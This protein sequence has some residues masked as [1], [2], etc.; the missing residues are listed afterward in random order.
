MALTKATYSM[1]D[2]APV[3]VL[4]YGA[5][6]DGVAD[7]TAAFEA[8]RDAAGV[9]QSVYVSP[10]VYIVDTCTLSVE[11]QNWILAKGAE[12]RSINGATADAFVITADGVKISGSGVFYNGG[13]AS[14]VTYHCIKVDGADN[15]IIEGVTVGG[16]KGP[17][18]GVYDANNTII[19]G[20]NFYDTWYAGVFAQPRT[21]N[22]SGIKISDCTI[23]NT[24]SVGTDYRY[25]FNVHDDA[26]S[27]Y[28]Y[29]DVVISDNLAQFPASSTQFPLLIEVFGGAG[30]LYRLQNVS[31]TGNTLAGG[32]MGCS[33][34][35]VKTATVTGNAVKNPYLY[36]IEA[37]NTKNGS[38]T[39]NTIEGGQRGIALNDTD[40]INCSVAGNS[41]TATTQACVY[42]SQITGLLAIG[43]NSYEPATGT[44]ITLQEC[45]NWSINGG[46][47]DGTV[48][49]TKVVLL[50]KSDEG[51]ISGISA[52]D[53]SENAVLFFADNAAAYNR[54][55]VSNCVW[56][57]VTNSLN[58]TTQLSGGASIGNQF[59]YIGNRSSTDTTYRRD[60]L[61]VLANVIDFI[62]PGTPE[63]TFT[64][65]VGSIF[66][67]TD[68]GAGTTLY[69][70]QTGTG[71]TGWVGK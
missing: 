11:D 2:G 26:G 32:G 21:K 57:N 14:G 38:I 61:D 59:S 17:C 28:T 39:G 33:L 25:G 66:R 22:V 45:K 30:A 46:V 29:S 58:I 1:I 20:V 49:G 6:G 5:I 10:G 7:D 43:A 65:A 16:A 19:R 27:V 15:V 60:Y 36:G 12:I 4:D 62:G 64:G 70:K 53:F 54:V 13:L 63:G 34:S 55:I 40:T 37:A 50:D 23:L 18:I 31:V 35:G 44:A 51:T 48:G 41:I 47:A 68:G 42:A 69:V 9:G 56:D 67:R 3:N 24:V 8:A 52:R 71:N